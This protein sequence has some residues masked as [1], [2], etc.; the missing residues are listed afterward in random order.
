MYT[1]AI[2]KLKEKIKDAKENAPEPVDYE[3]KITNIHAV[4][5]C[6]KRDDI[7]AVAKNEFL[8]KFI[9]RIDYDVIDYGNRKGGKAILDV[10]LK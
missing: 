4:I 7:S 8:K 2:E 1:V 10:Y 5:D 6:I 9:S 3:E